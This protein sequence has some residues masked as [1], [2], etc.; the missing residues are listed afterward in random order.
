MKAPGLVHGRTISTKELTEIRQLIAANPGW[1]RWRISRELCRL[2]DWR[3]ANGVDRDMAA[4]HLLNKLD[5]GGWIELPE[6]RRRRCLAPAPGQAELA[7]EAPPA[8]EGAP[9]GGSLADLRPVELVRVHRGSLQAHTLTHYL[10]NHHYLGHARPIG[11]NIRYLARDARGRDLACLCFEAAAWKVAARDRFIG[12]SDGQRRRR[13]P[14]LANNT[15]FLILPWVRVPH[16]ASHLLGLAA[17]LIEEHWREKYHSPLLALETFVERGRF[18]GTCYR[19]AN[20]H[21]LGQTR[22]RSRADTYQKIR[23]PVK[24]I[25]FYPLS[26]RWREELCRP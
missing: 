7:L 20:W 2:W 12:W 5:A 15:R 9:V 8:P 24:D 26:R 4:R 6:R 3:A 13:L 19:A 23:V 11:Q 14:W 25:Y 1:S 22:G 17:R 18:V 16:L 21:C 10:Q